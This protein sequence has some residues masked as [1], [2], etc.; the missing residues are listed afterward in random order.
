MKCE[1]CGSKFELAMGGH[2]NS[3]EPGWYF[4]FA[5]AFALAALIL[6]SLRIFEWA[7]LNMVFAA[8]MGGWAKEATSEGYPAECPRCGHV[9]KVR[10][11]SL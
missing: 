7:L 9:S 8:I 6:L 5:V 2:G 11:W 4:R 1:K 3:S 10:P